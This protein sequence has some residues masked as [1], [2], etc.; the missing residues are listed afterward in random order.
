MLARTPEQD[1]GMDDDFVRLFR[2]PERPDSLIEAEAAYRSA[3]AER[4]QVQARHE[5]SAR[6]LRA[7][8]PGQA[9]VLTHADHDQAGRA[10]SDQLAAE[11]EAKATVEHEREAYLAAVSAKLAKPLASYEQ[12][13]S[14]QIEMLADLLAVGMVLHT[15]SVAAK[16]QLQNGI[17]AIASYMLRHLS[18]L[19]AMMNRAAISATKRRK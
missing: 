10:L 19:T 7:Q 15:E 5:E 16:V 1:V 12:A 11:A 8:R 9:P 6:Q 18:G 13:I 14:R 17:P 3:V 2:L 4:E